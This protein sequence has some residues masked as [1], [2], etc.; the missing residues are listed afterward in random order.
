MAFNKTAVTSRFNQEGSH[1]TTNQCVL[2]KMNYYINE[3]ENFPHGNIK[4]NF[5]NLNTYFYM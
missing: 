3:I 2:L 5:W 4:L 1:L